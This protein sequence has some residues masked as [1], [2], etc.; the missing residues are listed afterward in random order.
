MP[1]PMVIAATALGLSFLVSAVRFVHWCLHADPKSLAR[2]GRSVLAVL[3]V[4]S[5]PLL[6][7]LMVMR[8]WSLAMLVATFILIVPALLG[9]RLLSQP[10]K[11]AGQLLFPAHIP[12][13][14]GGQLT[15]RILDDPELIRRSAAVLAAY[16]DR[17]GPGARTAAEWQEGRSA[18]GA[19]NDSAAGFMPQSEALAILGLQRGASASEIREAHRRL[20]LRIH[21]DRGGSNY[22]TLK[23]NQAK[24]TLLGGGNGRSRTSSRGS[25]RK[26]G[27]RRAHP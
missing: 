27:R 22:L 7:V 24:D 3:L 19:S 6:I 1:D 17:V 15:A 16:L 13:P 20:V 5:L 26:P 9:W 10:L 2:T 4:A 25:S 12:E 18:N 14:S 8:Q 23:I 21:P 11:A